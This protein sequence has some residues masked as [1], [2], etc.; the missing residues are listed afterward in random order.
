MC[1]FLQHQIWHEKTEDA[2]SGLT[3]T[4]LNVAESLKNSSKLQE[5]I[6]RNQMET[7][8]VQKQISEYTHSIAEHGDVLSKSMEQSR[9]HVRELMNELRASTDEQKSMIFSI[10]DRVTKLQSLL[11]SEVSWLYTV[12]FYAGCLLALYLATA[13]KRTEDARL[14]LF[15]ILTVNFILERVICNLTLEGSNEDMFDIY[16][17]EEQNPQTLLHFRIWTC[18]KLALLLSALVLLYKA[19]TF[20]DYNIIN[21]QLLQNIQKQNADLCRAVQLIKSNGKDVLD[22]AAEEEQ[23]ENEADDENSDDEDNLSY[24]SNVTDRTWKVDFS[25]NEDD[26]QSLETTPVR[27]IISPVPVVQDVNS[28]IDSFDESKIV[29]KRGRPRGSSR[30]SSRCT[31]PSPSVHTYN[32]RQRKQNQTFCGFENRGGN[33][34]ILDTES[35][36]SFGK[37]VANL[38]RQTKT[39]RKTLLKTITESKSKEENYQINGKLSIISDNDE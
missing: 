28:H 3:K 32:L 5:D 26:F 12:L 19:L 20:K 33:N 6:V 29:K 27:E 4:S 15:A 30:T 39:T 34:P 21:Y 16:L 36:D 14:W 13:A 10:F 37:L 22:R 9:V 2:I 1:Q 17:N 18:R 23:I 11:L 35:P 7:L 25:D 24:E 8:T 38:A 31:T